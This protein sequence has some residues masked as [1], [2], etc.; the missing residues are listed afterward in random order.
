MTPEDIKTLLRSWYSKPVFDMDG[1]YSYC[2]AD[3]VFTRIPFPPIVGVEANRQADEAMLVAYTEQKTTI[4]ELVVEGDTAV[5]R[6]SW[7]AVHS[8]TSP[9]LPI[10]PTGK[11]VA[12]KGCMVFHWKEGK[13]VDAWDYGDLLSF[14][15]QIGVI[16]PMG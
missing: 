7:Q 5:M 6:Y 3:F 16:P 11:T 4:D 13:M 1:F 10:P 12:M 2:S 8:G 14:L 15:Q 9:T